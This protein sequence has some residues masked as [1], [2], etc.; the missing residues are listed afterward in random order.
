MAQRPTLSHWRRLRPNS[1]SAPER[2]AARGRRCAMQST[3]SAMAARQ[4]LREHEKTAVCEHAR[5]AA[6]ALMSPGGRLPPGWRRHDSPLT[7][8][9]RGRGPRLAAGMP[10]I[11]DPTPVRQHVRAG[12]LGPRRQR[13]SSTATQL[14]AHANFDVTIGSR[15]M[16]ALGTVPR[17]SS[18]RASLRTKPLDAT[19]MRDATVARTNPVLGQGASLKLDACAPPRS[20]RDRNPRRANPR[21]ADKRCRTRS[22]EQSSRIASNSVSGSGRAGGLAAVDRCRCSAQV[23]APPGHKEQQSVEPFDRSLRSLCFAAG[24]ASAAALL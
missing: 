9:A 8:R 23:R 2:P 4:P 12:A 14:A 18:R 7:A 19:I 10:P 20:S 16:L 5:C 3:A 15:E 24:K 22:G 11:V 21:L 13:A 1:T 6:S 17:C